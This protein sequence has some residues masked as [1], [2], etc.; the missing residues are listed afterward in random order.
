LFRLSSA[1]VPVVVTIALSM[2]CGSSNRGFAQGG[3]S[4]SGGGSSDSPGFTSSSSGGT[5]GNGT[6]D[7][8]MPP[9]IASNLPPFVRDDTGGAGLPAAT[10]SQL[11]MGG[12]TCT[13]QVVYPYPDTMFPASGLAPI[14][15]WTGATDAAYIKLT[16]GDPHQV[17]YE[18][19]MGTSNPGRFPI[20]Q[21]GWINASIRTPT[22]KRTP[23]QV[24][25]TVKTGATLSTCMLSWYVAPGILNGA[26]Y[27]N[28]YDDPQAS[29]MLGN[30]PGATSFSGFGMGPG[31]QGA[32]LRLPFGHTTPEVFLLYK[33]PP[34]PVANAGPCYGCHSVSARGSSLAVTLHNY[35]T[36][37]FQVF[38]Y[39]VKTNPAPN[40]PPISTTGIPSATFGGLTPD[41]K[42]LLTMGNP[43]CTAGAETFPRSP[44]NFFLVEGPAVAKLWDVSTGQVVPTKGLTATNYMWMP[45]FSPN[46]DKVVFNYAKPG[47]NN[48]TDR[49]ELA[50]MDYDEPTQTFSNLQLLYHDD[51][52]APSL[53]YGGYTGFAGGGNILFGAGGCVNNVQ[54]QPY[55]QFNDTCSDVCY[56]GWPFFTPDGKKVIFARGTEP[57]FASQFPGSGRDA[58]SKSELYI[59]DV[60]TKVAHALTAANA[61]ATSMQ[62]G[63]ENYPTVMPVAA[64][65]QFWAFFT[66]RR[67]YGNFAN[68]GLGSPD[69]KKIWATAIDI[70]AA[71]GVDPSHP[72]FYLG[73]QGASG[74]IRAFPTLNPCKADGASCASGLDCCGGTCVGEGAQ[75]TCKPSTAQCATVDNRCTVAAD[76]C[77]ASPTSPPLDCIGGFCAMTAPPK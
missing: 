39:D 20:P 60:Q 17:L 53:P 50:T 25:L 57:E 40:P 5:F 64:G 58:P 22:Q 14:I 30:P 44:N 29:A 47:A 74:N 31:N 12:G 56:P 42:Y 32:V 28:S 38:G 8:G 3:S 6:D 61:G 41:G 59:I 72:P 35:A 70:G 62:L 43:D 45:Q 15:Q 52:P 48:R 37:S 46:G 19:A 4:S 16:Y 69:S 75:A 65:G 66:S 71:D 13:T 2:S 23:L 18:A 33:G 1:T 77:A 24:T 68:D 7:G 27:Y 51:G 21:V 49:R 36:K 55:V 73:G 54:P 76:C 63:Y 9:V 67:T 34:A 11:K 26:I 10:I